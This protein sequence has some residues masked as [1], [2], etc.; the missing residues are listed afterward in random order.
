MC[1]RGSTK[2]C[3]KPAVVPGEKPTDG[4]SWMSSS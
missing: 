2:E 4:E 3:E 1:G